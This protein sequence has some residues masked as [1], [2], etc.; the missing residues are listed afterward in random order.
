MPFILITALLLSAAAPDP[1]SDLFAYREELP[2][3]AAYLRPVMLEQDRGDDWATDYPRAAQAAGE[4]GTVKLSVLVDAQDRVASCAILESKASARLNAAACAILK[5]RGK[6]RHALSTAGQPVAATA[7]IE[8]VFHPKRLMR[9]PPPTPMTGIVRG[10]A[11]HDKTNLEFAAEPDWSPVL[12]ATR[13]ARGEAAISLHVYQSPNGEERRYC[14]VER[15]D[16]AAGKAA[17]S[18]LEKGAQLRLA[19]T[20]DHGRYGDTLQLLLQWDDGM[21]R[22]TGPTIRDGRDV[23]LK[24]WR[25]PWTSDAPLPR[26]GNAAVLLGSDG[27]V[28]SCRITDSTG[29][30]A[31]DIAACRHWLTRVEVTPPLDIFGKTFDVPMNGRLVFER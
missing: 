3:D 25:I 14:D 7:V 10:G 23:Q 5:R 9:V 21:M 6:L 17:C 18:L 20:R 13:T 8:M 26:E 22:T 4:G 12:A 24:G 29:Q 30:D 31:T 1:S 2:S 27:K 16:E 15:G 19:A 28:R 11:L